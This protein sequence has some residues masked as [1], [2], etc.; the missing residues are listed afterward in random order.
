[1]VQTW[2]SGRAHVFPGFPSRQVKQA[3]TGQWRENRRESQPVFDES[4]RAKST[5]LGRH[6]F[7]RWFSERNR[8]LPGLYGHGTRN[9]GH[10]NGKHNNRLLRSCHDA[11][12]KEQHSVRAL[13]AFTHFILC[14]CSPKAKMPVQ[15]GFSPI[16]TWSDGFFDWVISWKLTELWSF[17]LVNKKNLLIPPIRNIILFPV[18]QQR[19]TCWSRYILSFNS[20]KN[21]LYFSFTGP[22]ST[23]VFTLS[24]V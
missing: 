5:V 2:F 23:I 15:S 9:S 4:R 12:Q 16:V 11:G 3:V 24:L 1:M 22:L 7:W 10:Q 18:E 6:S 13:Y 21:L 8:R 20:S 14:F 17:E 19:G